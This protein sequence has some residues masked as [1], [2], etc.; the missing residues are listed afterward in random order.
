MFF[1]PH[2]KLYNLRWMF[3][4]TNGGRVSYTILYRYA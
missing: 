3:S 2:K 4:R 1:K